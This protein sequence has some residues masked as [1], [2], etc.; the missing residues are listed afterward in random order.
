MREPTTAPSIRL[1][2][3]QTLHDTMLMGQ[4]HIP[5]RATGYSCQTVDVW[6]IVLAAA[7][8]RTTIEAACADVER[9]PDA[10]T[11]RGYLTA[12]VSPADIP[13]Q[14]R[15][16]NALFRTLM[17]AWLAERPQEVRSIFMMNRTMGKI[18]LTTQFLGSVVGKHAP[19]RPASI[20]VPRPMSCSVM[21][22]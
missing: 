21:C 10:K 18:T 2:D 16:W 13:D 1:T 11:V 9:S 19:A 4:Q 17:P 5:L 22:G 20:A 3:Q 7:A 12:Q 14:E 6:R 8:R 15:P